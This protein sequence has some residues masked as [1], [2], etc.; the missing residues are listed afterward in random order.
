MANKHASLEALFTDIAK[1]IREKTGETNA[2]AAA[3]I[4]IVIREKLQ[5][6]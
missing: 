4:P 3:Q 1:A 2:I 6:Q 5:K